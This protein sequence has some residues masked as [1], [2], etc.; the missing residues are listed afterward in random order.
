M[1]LL[2]ADEL[3]KRQWEILLERVFI[4]LFGFVFALFSS[5]K[6]GVLA[7]AEFGFDVPPD[8]VNGA[9][10]GAGL[11]DVVFPLAVELVFKLRAEVGALERFG[12]EE[13]LEGVVLEVLADIG[14][15]LLTILERA[16]EGV[17]YAFG[18]VLLC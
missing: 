17:E 4:G 5:L 18:F 8:A 15:T 1:R 16:D 10:G 3:V 12:E 7:T 2:L 14:K 9:C 6:K 11:F 13:T